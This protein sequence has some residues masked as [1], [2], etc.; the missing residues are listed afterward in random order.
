MICSYSS[1]C[2][3]PSSFSFPQLPLVD[4]IRT[5]AQK[6]YGA[7]DIELSP[8][9]KAKIDYYNQQVR[10]LPSTTHLSVLLSASLLHRQRRRFSFLSFVFTCPGLQLS[11]HLHGQNSPVPVPHAWQEGRSHWIYPAHQRCSCQ[12]W[13]RLHL[14]TCGNGM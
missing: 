5:I 9:A 12:R 14:P 8:D 1:I 6:V 4:K 3:Y 2:P 7:D 10:S 13:C 11:A